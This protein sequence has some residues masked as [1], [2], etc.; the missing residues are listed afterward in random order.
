MITFTF[1]D[2]DT[3]Y[4]HGQIIIFFSYDKFSVMTFDV[5][6]ILMLLGFSEFHL[7]FSARNLP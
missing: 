2:T 1:L 4:E 5:L 3:D 6:G 7:T